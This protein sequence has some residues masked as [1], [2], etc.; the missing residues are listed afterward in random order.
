MD[1]VHAAQ[2]DLTSPEAITAWSNQ[3]KSKLGSRKLDVLV[4]NAGVLKVGVP[5]ASCD[6]KIIDLV[7]NTNVRGKTVNLRC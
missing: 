1:R 6:A 3:V 4:N 2:V 5:A 7:M